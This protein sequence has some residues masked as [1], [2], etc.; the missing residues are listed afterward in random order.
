MKVKKDLEIQSSDRMTYEEQLYRY[1]L[2]LPSINPTIDIDKRRIKVGLIINEPYVII[3]ENK[4]TNERKYKGLVYDI[5]EKIKE[6]MIDY[7]FIEFPIEEVSFKTHIQDLA[8]NKYDILVGNIWNIQ[9]RTSYVNFSRPLFLSK[10]VIGFKPLKTKEELFL[11]ML[12]KSYLI[13]LFILL[14]ISIL[15]GYI[16]YRVEKY[17]G[18]R[19]AIWTTIGSFLGETGWLFERSRLH[20]TAFVIII[21]TMVIAYYYTV[22]LQAT[23]TSDILLKQKQEINIDNLQ[24]KFFVFSKEYDISSLLKKYKIR[25]ELV[26]I[27]KN[28]LVDYYLTNNEK[29]DGYIVDYEQIK[30]DQKTHSDIEITKDNFGYQENCL[31]MKIGDTK[32]AEDINIGIAKLQTMETIKNICIGYIGNEDARLCIL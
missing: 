3:E 29:Y 11:E 20:Y 15:F 5:W 17:R 12:K 32:L 30:Q 8:K 6:T 31:A 18:L 1:Q 23:A 13:P 22:F 16:L 10:I 28:E 9:E 21:F 25:Y 27:P 24:Y 14:L 19:R 4:E 26:D 2:G 7:E